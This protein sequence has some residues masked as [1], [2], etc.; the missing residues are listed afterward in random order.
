MAAVGGSVKPHQP[1]RDTDHISSNQPK[2]NRPNT[3]PNW[4]QHTGRGLC[5]L[6]QKPGNRAAACPTGRPQRYDDR[7]RQPVHGHAA[8][9]I[10]DGDEYSFPVIGGGSVLEKDNLP[11]RKGLIGDQVVT[12]LR[13]TGSTGVMNKADLV[14]PSQFTVR[15]QK[16]MMVNSRLQEFPVAWIQVATPVFS[17]YVQALCCLIRFTT[18]SSETFQGC[19]RIY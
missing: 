7:M 1:N 10:E 4:N 18:W 2:P 15:N 19:I 8:C 12:V 13:D 5:Y 14:H 9:L 11:L 6:C 16:L 3:G 17:G